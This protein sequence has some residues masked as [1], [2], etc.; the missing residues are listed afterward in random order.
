MQNSTNTVRID[1]N[2]AAEMRDHRSGYASYIDLPVIG[3]N[4]T[5]DNKL[6]PQIFKI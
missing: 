1:S 2:I 6:R 5:S 4:L 3:N